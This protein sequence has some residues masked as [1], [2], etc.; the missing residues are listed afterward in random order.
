MQCDKHKMNVQSTKYQTAPLKAKMVTA[1][2]FTNYSFIL[3]LI[4]FPYS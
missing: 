1:T 4:F 2:F 3:L